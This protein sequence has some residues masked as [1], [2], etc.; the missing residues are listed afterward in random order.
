VDVGKVIGIV[1]IMVLPT[2]IVG[3]VFAMPRSLGVLRR[4]VASRRATSVL[5]PRHAPIE[6]L[7]SDLRRLLH[8][9]DNLK[10]STGVPMKAHRLLALEAAVADRATETASALGVPCPERDDRRT[11]SRPDLRR[12]L[13]DLGEAGLVLPAS[14]TLLGVEGQN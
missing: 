3:A 1:V 4:R 5:E 9:H 8:Q 6:Q 12:L 11:L 7:A 10:R 14:S 13:R 2:L